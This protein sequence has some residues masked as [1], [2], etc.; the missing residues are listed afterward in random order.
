ARTAVGS[1]VMTLAVWLAVTALPGDPPA[2]IEAVV[3]MLV[4]VVV[5]LAALSR[6]RVREVAEIIRRVRARVSR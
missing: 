6:M 1:V 5:Y 3:G 2:L 4:G